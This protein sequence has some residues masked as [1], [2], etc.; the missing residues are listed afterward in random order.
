MDDMELSEFVPEASGS[1]LMRAVRVGE[2]F[3][4]GNADVRRSLLGHAG[5][6]PN[7]GAGPGPLSPV[8]GAGLSWDGRTARPLIAVMDL[9][10]PDFGQPFEALPGL[11]REVLTSYFTGYSVGSHAP[12][13]ILEDLRSTIVLGVSPAQAF[14]LAGVAATTDQGLFGPN[15]VLGTA[16]YLPN[17]RPG[18]LTAGHV[19][20]QTNANIAAV[21]FGPLGAVHHSVHP[22][23]AAIGA[24]VA[25]A[26]SVGIPSQPSVNRGLSVTATG[27]AVRRATLD[28]C[29]PSTPTPTAVVVTGFFLWYAPDSAQADWAD[30][31]IVPSCAGPGDSGAPAFL[32]GTSIVVGHVVGGV[33]SKYTLIQAIDTQ[34]SAVGCSFRATP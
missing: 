20:S 27:A 30:C 26:A 33:P 4:R 29:T 31:Y 32:Q 6:R 28:V 1:D 18:I 10:T 2:T 12:G 25:D 34:L 22:W 23:A 24:I 3:R 16:I 13:A 5:G 8:L 7:T 21:G 19:A 11:A 14:D 9:E 15:G 17:N